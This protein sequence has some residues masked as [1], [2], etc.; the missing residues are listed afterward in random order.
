MSILCICRWCL[1]KTNKCVL[2]WFICCRLIDN[3]P[4]ATPLI[5]SEHGDVQYNH[6]YP[7]GMSVGEKNYINNHLK[8]TLLYHKPS[9]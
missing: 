2:V 6:G 9:P 3:L 7:L 8:F 5:N 4:A 1:I